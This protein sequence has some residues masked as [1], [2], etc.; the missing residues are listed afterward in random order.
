M[1]KF[2]IKSQ[3]C[4][5]LRAFF[6]GKFEYLETVFNTNSVKHLTNIMSAR[7]PVVQPRLP[8]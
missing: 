2:H 1:T 4:C 8:S 5:D 6:S 3:K 7:S